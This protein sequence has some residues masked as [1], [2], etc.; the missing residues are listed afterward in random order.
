[1]QSVLRNLLVMG[2]VFISN[3]AM[4]RVRPSITKFMCDYMNKFRVRTVGKNLIL[5][6]HLPPLNSAA[7]SRFVRS[8]LIEK[9]TGPSH[10]QIAI[11]NSCPQNCDYCYNKDRSGRVMDKSTIRR[12]A[13]ELKDMGVVWIGLTGGEPLLNPHIVEIVNDIAGDCAVKLF[14]TGCGLTDGLAERLR[15]AGLFSVSVSLDHW[16]EEVHDAR[17][18]YPGA[19]KQ[20]IKAIETFRNLGDMDVGV[21]AVLSPEM[22]N[23]DGALEFIRFLETLNIHE[24]W[25][26]EAKPT[27]ET[28]WREDMVI[29]DEDRLRLVAMQD[30]YNK[31][32][33]MTINYLGHF[34]GRE[35]FGCNAGH[36]MVYVDAF[37]E[38]SPCVFTPMSFGNI[39]QESVRDIFRRMKSYFPSDNSCFINRNY[40]LLAKY[41]DGSKILSA[42]KSSK[43]M[44]EVVFENYSAFFKLYYGGRT[45]KESMNKRVSRRL[46]GIGG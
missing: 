22:I 25:L 32:G 16:S 37:G 44:N 6:S 10:A 31:S 34:E 9:T 36:K 28:F 29:N 40:K 4:I 35:C 8:H 5:H 15:D 14:T 11:T 45:R 21:S 18:R 27:T 24:A 19:F 1:M 3:P 12:V 20:A 30:E 2:R 7:Y 42:E 38:V 13:R 26:S 17:R 23:T 33:G 41:S 46:E 43:L 39:H